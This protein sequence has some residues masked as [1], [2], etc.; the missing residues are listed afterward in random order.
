[1]S[2]TTHRVS[3]IRRDELRVRLGRL[4]PVGRQAVREAWTVERGKSLLVVRGIA[5]DD[6]TAEDL[7]E[8]YAAADA[9]FEELAPSTGAAETDAED[10]MGAFESAAGYRARMYERHS[11]MRP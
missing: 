3:G 10:A 6:A 11:E 1:M 7:V 4:G 8:A 2:T 9:E 5:E